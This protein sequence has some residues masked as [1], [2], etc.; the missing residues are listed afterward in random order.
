MAVI[1]PDVSCSVMATMAYEWSPN[2]LSYL[3]YTQKISHMPMQVQ[4]LLYK[5]AGLQLVRTWFLKFDPVRIIG[6]RVRVCVCVCPRPRLLITN[7][8]IWHKMN[9]IRLV[10][11]VLQ[12]LSGNCSCYH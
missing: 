4:G 6:M 12:L 5:H 10:K 7:G 3:G 1:D 8:V 11:Q 2:A 9:L